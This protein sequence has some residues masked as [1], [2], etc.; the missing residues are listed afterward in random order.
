M[1]KPAILEPQPGM[2]P[3]ELKRHRQY[4]NWRTEEVKNIDTKVP[5]MPNG[6]HAK[7]NDPETWSDFDSV[8]Q[9]LTASFYKPI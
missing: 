7:S 2:I 1:K 8:V 4:V 6:K 5:Y 9:A 3:Q